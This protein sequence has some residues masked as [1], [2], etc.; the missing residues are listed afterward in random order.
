MKASL[1]DSRPILSARERKII[2]GSSEWGGHPELHMSI[3]SR[4][5]LARERL[6]R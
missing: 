2:V 3:I 6:A 1:P 5:V 4:L